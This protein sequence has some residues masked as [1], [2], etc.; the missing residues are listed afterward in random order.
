MGSDHHEEKPFTKFDHFKQRGDDFL[1]IELFVNSKHAYLQALE[2]HPDDSYIQ[3]QLKV[4]TGLLKTERHRIYAIL[5]AF[6]VIAL[7]ALLIF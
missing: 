4:V 5:G 1:K 6:A 2:F 7:L 3:S